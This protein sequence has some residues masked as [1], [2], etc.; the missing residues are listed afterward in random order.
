MNAH[1]VDALPE[2]LVRSRMRI[3]ALPPNTP[4]LL[5][6]LSDERLSLAEV[7]RM[8]E[9]YPP[10]AARIIGLANSSWSAPAS[11]ITSL[12]QACARMGL[13]VVRSVSVGLAVGTPF[14]PQR[15]PGFDSE[16]FWAAAMLTADAAAW[17]CGGPLQGWSELEA[18]TARTAGLLHNLGL[19]WLADRMPQQTGAALSAVQ[20]DAQL[21]LNRALLTHCGIDY[22]TA[23]AV[24]AAEWNLPGVLTVAIGQHADPDYRDEH[25]T[26]AHTIGIAESMVAAVWKTSD[27][28]PPDSVAIDVPQRQSIL[29][30]IAGQLDDARELARSL[31]P[32]RVVR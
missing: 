16:R 7:G 13:D 23:G 9:R 10:I 3:P 12:P 21:S 11:P 26:A 31:F 32:A 8:L 1:S 15:C 22:P 5:R 20:Q 2:A 28:L 14:K 6:Q 29:D 25:W 4:Q 17:L 30:R 24:L 18:G 27:W 19:L